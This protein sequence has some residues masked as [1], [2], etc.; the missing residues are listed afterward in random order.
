MKLN[1]SKVGE[2]PPFPKVRTDA[3]APAYEG[4][5]QALSCTLCSLVWK[6]SFLASRQS[7]GVI[8]PIVRQP[9]LCQAHSRGARSR[10]ARMDC[11]LVG[12]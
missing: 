4:R 8:V 5:K 10:Q 3:I 6:D 11:G 7:K 12:Y 1:G 2:W 9:R